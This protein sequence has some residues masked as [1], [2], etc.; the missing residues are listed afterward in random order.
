MIQKDTDGCSVRVAKG[1]RIVLSGW[2]RDRRRETAIDVDHAGAGDQQEGGGAA[3]D[4][5]WLER[6]DA[7]NQS[8]SQ[9]GNP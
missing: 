9:A 5:K 2:I 4:A 3:I 8:Q 7:S 6:E 1:G